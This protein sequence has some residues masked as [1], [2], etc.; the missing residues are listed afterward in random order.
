MSTHRVPCGAA[1]IDL[2]REAARK[3]ADRALTVTAGE[4]AV[5]L[6]GPLREFLLALGREEARQRAIC[7]CQVS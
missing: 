2:G 1:L 5:T 4:V 3:R 7:G 6:M